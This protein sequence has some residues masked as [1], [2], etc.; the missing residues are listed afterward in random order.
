MKYIKIKY[1]ELLA[2]IGFYF[3]S[4]FISAIS[5]YFEADSMRFGLSVSLAIF[6]SLIIIH[7][8]SIFIPLKIYYIV[9]IAFLLIS[10]HFIISGFI[11]SGRDI[12]RFSGS[13]LFIIII[14]IS[15]LIFLRAIL[16]IRDKIFNASIFFGFY[17]L[18][19]IA[20]ISILMQKNYLIESKMMIIFS[21]PS[22]FS[23]SFLPFLL[24]VVI[25]DKSRVNKIIYIALSLGISF[26]VENLTLV[27]GVLLIFFLTPLKSN[28]FILKF[29]GF[30]F[31]LIIFKFLNNSYFSERLDFSEN[32]LNLSVLVFLSGWERAYLT[33]VDSFGIGL[34]FQQLGIVGEA[35]IYQ[36]LLMNELS[37]NNLNLLDGG[38]LAP[39]II[40]EM[41]IIG[42]LC[43]ILYIVY[44][45]K[46]A[47]L[48]K[49]YQTQ[50]SRVIFFHCIFLMF[51]IELF[52]R[53][54][55]Y[56]SISSFLFISSLHR[57]YLPM[58]YLKG[59]EF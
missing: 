52:V 49:K 9:T 21:E 28:K 50:D 4:I 47:I 58:Q 7:G 32:N 12:F 51:F 17:Y 29:F 15:S 19:I 13:L 11:F 6:F 48:I 38:S 43:I 42:V 10:L 2:I 5:V 1:N 27:V 44:F 31:I 26:L 30:L 56:F 45:I 25:T 23:I 40:A 37:G 20:F 14:Y 16:K 54:M 36:S 35:G 59:R 57:F 41:G 55:G 46:V 3:I 34:G 39:K 24:Y 18:I 22:H 8:F 53:G 33:F